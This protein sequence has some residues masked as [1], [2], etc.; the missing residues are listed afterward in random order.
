MYRLATLAVLM[1][2]V[3]PS[4]SAAAPAA[5]GEADRT[6]L[7]CDEHEAKWHV[8]RARTLIHDG[9]ARHR[10]PDPSPMRADEK[11][12]LRR[13][14]FCLLDDER[15]DRIAAF[16]DRVADAYHE[17]L[18]AE[19]P[20]WPTPESLG[21]SSATL[22]AIRACESGGNYAT[23]TGNGYYGAYQFNLDAWA[24]V[25]GTG[26]PSDASPAEQD[27]RAALLYRRMGP[28][29]WPVCGV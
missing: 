20:E 24:L 25:G 9:Y 16:R 8:K 4:S 1:S 27:Y 19:N 12:G 3:A 17:R 2:A 14:K 10:M 23:N 29:P 5:P 18:A 15:R 22:A 6:P 26:L 7:T 28:G 11:R 13:H 21:V